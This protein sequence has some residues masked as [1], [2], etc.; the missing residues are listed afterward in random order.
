[1][2]SSFSSTALNDTSFSLLR[3]SAPIVAFL[4]L[5]RVDRNENGV[6]RFALPD[7]GRDRGIAGIAAVPVKLVIDLDRL[8]HGWQTGRRE[9]N[10]RRNGVVLEHVTA[11]GPHI[12]GGD[13]E[14]DRRCRQLLEIDQIGQNLAQRIFPLGFI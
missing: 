2:R 12:G 8:K 9:Q 6:L 11:A 7:Q 4:A 14:L 5:D 13:E 1:M 3:I 10:L